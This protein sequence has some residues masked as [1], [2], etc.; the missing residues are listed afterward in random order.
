MIRVR[1]R[2]GRADYRVRVVRGLLSRVGPLLRAAG[3]RGS[4]AL[5][6]DRTVGRLYGVR[7]STGLRRAGF[8]V[9]A[10]SIPDGERAKS[11]ETFRRLCEQWARDR[12]DRETLVLALGGGVVSDVAGYA[13]ASYA[14][15]LE[16]A[17]VPTTLLAQADASIGGKVGINL[18]A[19]KNLLGAYHHP[20]AVFADPDT[21]VTLSARAY[22]SGLAEVVKMGVIRRPGILD[23]L[24][25]LSRRGTLRSA[26]AV[27]PLIRAAASEKAAIVSADERDAGVRR[28]LNFGHTVGHALEAASA[29]RGYLH[30]EAVS[31]GMT[32]ALRLSVAEA[33][34]DPSDAAAVEALQRALGLPTRLAR[35]PGEDFWR[36][37][38]MDKKRGRGRLRMVLCPAI[39]RSKVFEMSSLTA[40]RRIVRG[41]VRLP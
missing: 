21:L 4:V 32:A 23:D 9:L 20:A 33:G 37:L 12:I 1:V 25:A 19:G 36:A 35:P 38:G 41:L 28:V 18:D 5:V 26:A 7:V 34:L 13:A 40:L 6:S 16:W 17:I 39:G 27:A 11:F 29:Y 14:R 31:V 24:A 10:Y 3:R 15:G 8:R 22:R 30:G 2:R